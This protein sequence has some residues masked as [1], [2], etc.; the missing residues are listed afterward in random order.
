MRRGLARVTSGQGVYAVRV[1]SFRSSTNALLLR[2]RRSMLHA[3]PSYLQRDYRACSW[4]YQP[5]SFRTASIQRVP[6]SVFY[7]STTILLVVCDRFSPNEVVVVW[8]ARCLP[9]RTVETCQGQTKV[10]G[11]SVF[12]EGAVEQRCVAGKRDDRL[13]SSS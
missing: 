6:I 1:A 2:A 10:R 5:P 8:R 3:S 13:S 9:G 7:R 11:Y 4:N 12:L